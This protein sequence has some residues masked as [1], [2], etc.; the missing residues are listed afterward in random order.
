[1]STKCKKVKKEREFEKEEL[2]LFCR[3]RVPNLVSVFRAQSVRAI[4]LSYTYTQDVHEKIDESRF[5]R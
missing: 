5:A 3:S 2:T 1:M 4:P